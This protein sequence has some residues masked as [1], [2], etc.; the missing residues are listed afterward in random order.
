MNTN[1]A[2]PDWKPRQIVT[3][4]IFV[5]LVIAGFFLL[6]RFRDVLFILFVSIVIST[7][8]SPGVQWL[9]R[10]GIP[11]A[12]GVILI[13]LLVVLL[14]VG[15]FLLALPP[16][17]QQGISIAASIPEYYR[18]I[19]EWLVTSPSTVLQQIGLRLPSELSFF[20]DQAPADPA[21]Q[22][23]RFREQVS[24][25]LEYAGYLVRGVLAVIGV[26]LL[27]FYW[28]LDREK[29]I[30]SLFLLIPQQKRDNAREIV[31]SIQ[32]KLGAF[33]IGQTILCVV[34]GS[35]SLAAYLLI[36]LPNALLLAIFAGIMEAVPV[37]GPTIGAIPAVL[38]AIASNEPAKVVWIVV[39]TV[40]IQFLENNLLVPRVGRAV[41]VNPIVTLL[42]LA[43]FA[44]LFGIA[45][46]VL[47]IPLAAILQLAVD[48]LVL[49]TKDT[50]VE[51]PEGRDAFSALQ[52]ELQ[53][54]TG[55]VRKH[56]RE[57]EMPAR[58]EEDRIEEDVETL[59]KELEEI[60]A[61]A[62]RTDGQ[63]RN[64]V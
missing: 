40:L 38:I 4:T 24:M 37:F 28:T 45:G 32:E 54:L 26:F 23:E 49:K 30:R 53:E 21:D 46:A 62:S 17:I 39:A 13:Y 55:D 47:A 6:V 52:L 48:R 15:F 51:E 7:A 42:A 60:L 10:R 8:I 5:V 50:E 11:R 61:S 18:N 59:A 12:A 64:G 19:Y 1:T 63:R 34:I 33:V 22:N 41:G 58:K 16:I 35:L 31:D 14:L 2:F 36:G 29:T 43:A 25:V 57:K 27:A 44:S 56:F 9:Q 20:S 3:G